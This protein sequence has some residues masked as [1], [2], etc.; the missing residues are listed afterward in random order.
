MHC[1]P[2][3]FLTFYTKMQFA[4]EQTFISIFL[5]LPEL[6]SSPW[7]TAKTF[8]RPAANYRLHNFV[9]YDKIELVF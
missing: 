6:S 4:P 7:V 3:F 8:L 1:E 2:V 9:K 5:N